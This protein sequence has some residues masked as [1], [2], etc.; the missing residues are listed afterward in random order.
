MVSGY[1]GLGGKTII[2]ATAS[3]KITMR[4]V[5]DQEP[6]VIAERAMAH[7]RARCPETVTLEISPPFG[8][9]PVLT[10]IKH[11]IVQAAAEALHEAF[12]EP[13]ALIRQGGTIPVAGTFGLDMGWPTLLMGFGLS[14]DNTHSPNERFRI[15]SLFQGAK[16][17]AALMARLG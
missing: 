7:L 3:A 11:P 15:E 8:A 4:L 12:G 16:A 5:P 2:P 14:T 10:D 17:S 6:S 13:A 9:R 1:T